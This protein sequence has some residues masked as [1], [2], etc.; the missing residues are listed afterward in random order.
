MFNQMLFKEFLIGL[1]SIANL[2]ILCIYRIEKNN[3]LPRRKEN[4]ISEKM[5]NDS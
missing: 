2:R 5:K 4:D 3:V 1:V